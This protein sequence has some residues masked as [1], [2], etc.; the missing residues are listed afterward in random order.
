MKK[1][2]AKRKFALIFLGIALGIFLTVGQ[3]LIPFT[4][5]D[6]NG[7]ANAIKLGIDLEGG[8]LAVYNVAPGE[9]TTDFDQEVDAT[10][11]RLQSLIA[12]KGY[13]EATVVKQGGGVEGTQIRVEVPDVD[14]PSDIFEL[15]G[16]P[17]KLELKKTNDVNAPAELTGDNIQS[18]VASYQDG[19]YGV[20]IVFDGEGTDA[21]ATLTA[22]LVEG[23]TL[24]ER[25]LHIFIGGT[26]YSS[27]EVQ[28]VI[29]DGRTFISGSMPDLEAAEDYATKILS[30]TFSVELELSSNSV[31]SA[32]LGED[33]LRLGLI[34]GIIG[35]VLVFAFMVYM[36]GTF[37]LLADIALMIYLLLLMFF[38]Q[39]IPVV[40]L[41][42]PGIAGI[43]LSLGMA[44]DANVI[45]FERIKDEY[46]TG[47]KIPA[48]I[49]SGF[50]KATSAILDANITT[51][52]ASVILYIL[53][54]G[55]IKGFA[56][57]LLI[58]IVISMFTALIVTKKLVNAYLPINSA[59][60]KP[61]K[62]TR[63]DEVDELV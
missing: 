59:N 27:P 56:I 55:P 2:Q 45:I 17:A 54:T 35:I 29:S 48:S 4:D 41:T 43:I 53:G 38:L 25:Q 6:Y 1:R 57:T 52:I 34:A 32:T 12:E 10:I 24:E 40:Q 30:G 23:S 20:S 58:G 36:Y 16:Q 42:L 28:S 11:L 15:I 63:E 26:L 51:I 47:K 13:T 60:P 50:D 49:K 61:Y 44:V 33:A 18:V 7:F 31:V 62:L 14:D 9:N 19:K 37:G 5:Y 21:F 39:A 22:E 8:V 3:F 46:R